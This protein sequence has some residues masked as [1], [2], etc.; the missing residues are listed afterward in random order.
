MTEEYTKE[1]KTLIAKTIKEAIKKASTI[2][3]KKSIATRPTKFPRWATVPY[4]DPVVGGS[5]VVEPPD[6]QKDIGWLRKQKPPANYTNWLFNLIYLWLEYLD[7]TVEENYTLQQIRFFDGGY[8]SLGAVVIPADNT[9]PQITEGAQIISKVFTP[10][11]AT[12][13]ILVEIT[14]YVTSSATAIVAASLFKDSD[15]DALA[16]GFANLTAGDEMIPITFRHEFSS[17]SL[18]PITFT[19]RTGASA[20]NIFYNG[21]ISIALYNGT[22]GSN[23]IITEYK[24]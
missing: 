1:E 3:T 8:Q 22:I 5:N 9:K 12:S 19:I 11:S 18:D 4:V 17:V 24:T 10:L 16:T 15:V 7:G 21:T 14:V 2:K 23:M 13:K 6:Q 20:G